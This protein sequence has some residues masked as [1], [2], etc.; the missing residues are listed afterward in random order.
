MNNLTIF[1][2]FY[3][4]KYHVP[5]KEIYVPLQCGSKDNPKICDLGDETG[6]NISEHNK[7]WSEI[8]GLYWARF[9]YAPLE[10]VGLCSYRRFFNFKFN[11]LLP[12]KIYS[13]DLAKKVDVYDVP[14]LKS[15]FSEFDIVLPKY[16]TYKDCIKN[17]LYSTYVKEDMDLLF[18]TVRE[19]SPNIHWAINK[20]L[21]SNKMYGHN[22]FILPKN[23]YIEY[24]DWVFDILEKF[25]SKTNPDNYP[26]KHIRLYGY[27]HEILLNIYVISN[28]LKI[29]HSQIDWF[30]EGKEK[31][32]FNKLYY[33]L[34]ANIYYRIRLFLKF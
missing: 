27:A 2:M 3:K 8:T 28:N 1:V 6:K 5:Q 30:K 25:R 16:F 15:I 26:I 12:V 17:V 20:F 31:Y 14:N 10:Y 32:R 21:G 19:I 11:P 4:D 9:N 22:M 23:D 18:D 33:I 29:A 34:A 13:K 7:Y 24:C